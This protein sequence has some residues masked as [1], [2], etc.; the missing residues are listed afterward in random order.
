M[1]TLENLHTRTTS[2]DVSLAN[3]N[4][5]VHQ[6]CS[7]RVQRTCTCLPWLVDFFIPYLTYLPSPISH[8]RRFGQQHPRSTSFCTPDAAFTDTVERFG[9]LS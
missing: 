5:Y 2:D 9:E 4:T 6:G 1:L 7:V 3:P 8:T